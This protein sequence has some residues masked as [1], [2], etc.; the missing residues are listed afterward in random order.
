ME[1]A[2]WTK[3]DASE[4]S[5]LGITNLHFCNLVIANPN[6][7]VR[8]ILHSALIFSRFLKEKE[9][10]IDSFWLLYCFDILEVK[11]AVSL[12]NLFS[13]KKRL[14]FICWFFRSLYL[15]SVLIKQ[16]IV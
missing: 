4:P 3:R 6:A 12:A 7:K 13:P 16:L 9:Q 11:S 8:Q 10:I 15:C 14:E 5:W 2:F 1:P